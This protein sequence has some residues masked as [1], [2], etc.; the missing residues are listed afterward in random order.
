MNMPPPP[1][2]LNNSV[3]N[4]GEMMAGQ[5]GMFDPITAD[6][7]EE[8]PGPGF[9]KRWIKQY[10]IQHPESPSRFRLGMY[11]KIMN[12]EPPR[13]NNLTLKWE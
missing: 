10:I 5:N 2:T 1:R 8:Y 6:P 3:I 13:R 7:I 9:N 12:L 4:S 11:K